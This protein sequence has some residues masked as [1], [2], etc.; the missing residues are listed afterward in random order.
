MRRKLG[1]LLVFGL[2]VCL[3]AG[4]TA[5]AESSQGGQDR[6]SIHTEVD[7]PALE[8]EILLG[9]NGQITYGK[10]VPVRVTVR[11]SGEDLEGTVAVNAYVSR[12]K[13]DRFE[14]DIF[15]PGGGERTVVLPVTVE[16]RQDLFTVEILKDGKVI[17]AVNAWPESIINP[18]AMLVGVL[19]SRPRNLANLNITQE[20]DPLKRYEYW[21]TVALEPETLPD[22]P[23][24]LDSFGIIVLDDTDPALLTEK[25]QKA[26]RDWVHS[27][28]VLLCGG[29]S[30]APQNLAFLGEMTPLHVTDFSV[31]DSVVSSLG[32]WLGQKTSSSRPEIALARME[33]AEPLAKDQDGNGLIW[34]M[35]AGNGLVYVL[36]WESGDPVLNTETMMHPFY[37]QLLLLQDPD[38]YNRILY[39]TGESGARYIPGE[40]AT[41]R[42]QNPMPVAAAIIAGGAV[43]SGVAW[44]LLRKRG[45]TQWM[46]A[47]LPA[48]ALVAAGGT[49][50]LAGNSSLNR[51]V[52]VTAV[53][54]LQ[55]ASGRMTR[56]TGVIAAAPKAGLHSYR[57]EG[58]QLDVIM[59]DDNY[60][61]GTDDDENTTVREPSTLRVVR[62]SGDNSGIAVNTETPWESVRLSAVRD[63]EETGRVEAE[64]WMESDGFHGTVHNGMPYGLKEGAVVCMYGYVKI[65]ALAPGESADFVLVSDVAQDPYDPKFENGKMF[66]NSTASIYTVVSNMLYGPNADTYDGGD[67]SQIGMITAASDALSGYGS[68]GSGQSGAAFLYTAEPDDAAG[69]QV[70]A[71]LADEQGSESKNAEGGKTDG[72]NELVRLNAAIRYLTVGKTG[73]VFY[74][75]GMISAVRCLTDS[76]GLPTEDYPEDS[77]QKY[78][79]YMLDENP[80][81]RFTAEELRKMEITRIV[82]GMDEWTVNDARCFVLNT[83]LRTWVEI[84]ANTPL[85]R[86][87]Q[88]VDANGNI[89]FQFRPVQP[90]SYS[91]MNTPTL[92]VE[93]R[94]SDE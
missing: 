24:L 89:F 79:Y 87:E 40:E 53:N 50:L 6:E 25:Q 83:R 81:F 8:A 10:A 93:G 54:L 90:D 42:L 11:N 49:A 45:K 66:L 68:R 26:L 37:Q 70:P 47:V 17:L 59:Y 82:V 72:R 16:T 32:N 29:G 74:A 77:S 3:L 21:Q 73:V 78:Y 23:A 39:T 71:L 41:I 38:M 69:F 5:A 52:A 34:R 28:R 63:E 60:Y 19:S 58:E 44:L 57:L 76:S 33:G 36:A 35:T 7:N 30:T 4:C 48:V 31:S 65:P 80:T 64:I 1:R 94:I 86:P 20:S 13:Y 56:Y 85:Q 55:D 88:Y 84:Q 9:Y 75:P 91:S 67:Y 2:I 22:D 43:L 46:W 27:G 12:V 61:W 62:R 14:T 18:S 15:V 92:T 51:P